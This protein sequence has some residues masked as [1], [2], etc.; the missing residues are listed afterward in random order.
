MRLRSVPEVY[1]AAYRRYI[2]FSV[3]EPYR[4]IIAL[5]PQ[6]I[7]LFSHQLFSLSKTIESPCQKYTVGCK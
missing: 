2:V 5:D 1:R 7:L 6:A 3:P 4:A